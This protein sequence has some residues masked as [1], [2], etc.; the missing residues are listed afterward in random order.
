ML[1]TPATEGDD[2]PGNRPVASAKDDVGR[3]GGRCCE[4]G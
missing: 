3:F 4:Q 2:G 1:T